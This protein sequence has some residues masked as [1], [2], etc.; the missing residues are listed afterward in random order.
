MDRV[1]VKTQVITRAIAE[2]TM[3]TAWFIRVR[4]LCDEGGIETPEHLFK[5][6]STGVA[7]IS[8]PSLEA[9]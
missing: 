2:N 8:A 5:W 3:P 9:F 7:P 4:T 6:V 1:G